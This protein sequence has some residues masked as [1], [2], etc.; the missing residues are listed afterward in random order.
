MKKRIPYN[1]HFTVKVAMPSKLQSIKWVAKFHLLLGVPL[2]TDNVISLL[3]LEAT[4]AEP[5]FKIIQLGVLPSTDTLFSVGFALN[6][7]L[8]Q[9]V[10]SI[11][12][13]MAEFPLP[14]CNF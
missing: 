5:S 9:F 6:E 3:S 2:L 4:S 1:Y 12:Y 14:F 11:F 13:D 10:L 8:E 7:E